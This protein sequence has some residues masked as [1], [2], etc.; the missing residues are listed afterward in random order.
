MYLLGEKQVLTVTR[1]GEIGCYLGD[2][3]DSRA[4]DVLLPAKWMPNGTQIGDKIEVFVYKDSEDRPIATTMEPALTLG[5]TAVLRVVDTTR[6][7]AFLDW[8]LEKDLLLPFHEQNGRLHEGDECLV[9]L[10][11]DKS[12]RLCASM[13]KVYHALSTDT[14]Y[15]KDDVVDGFVYE[16]SDEYGAYVAVDGKYS[17]RIAPQEMRG[18]VSAGRRMTARVARVLPDGKMDLTLQKKVADQMA[19]D[20]EA[21]LSEIRARGGSLPFTDKA[22]AEVIREAFGMSKNAFKRAVGRLLKQG[23]IAIDTD[24]IRMK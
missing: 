1:V 13:K 4:Q 5:Q 14:P 21:V 15:V 11:I 8:G 12:G 10:Y 2:H 17:A 7:G 16:I 23:K 18:A 19:D 9:T 20:A 3:Y 6:I 24:Q 22:D